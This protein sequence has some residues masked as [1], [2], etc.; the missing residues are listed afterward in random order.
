MA[1]KR[2]GD[3][4]TLVVKRGADTVTLKFVFRRTAPGK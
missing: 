4:A 3:A 2:W 1:A